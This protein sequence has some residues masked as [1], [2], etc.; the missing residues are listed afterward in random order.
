MFHYAF[1][2][3]DKDFKNYTCREAMDPHAIVSGITSLPDE[4]LAAVLFRIPFGK[5]KVAMQ[6]VNRWVGLK[7]IRLGFLSKRLISHLYS[8]HYFHSLSSVT[9]SNVDH[10]AVYIT[11]T[12]DFH[13]Q[14]KP[15]GPD[16]DH[17]PP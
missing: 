9:N 1:N 16:P 10:A 11:K 12:L 13:R 6:R 15:A 17:F 4:L 2:E 7:N 3:I 8:S 5:A 14:Q